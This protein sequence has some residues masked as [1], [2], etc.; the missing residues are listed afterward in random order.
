LDILFRPILNPLAVVFDPLTQ[1]ADSSDWR[2]AFVTDDL[3]KAELRRRILEPR[4]FP[5]KE[6]AVC[7]RVG[8]P[9]TQSAW[10]SILTERK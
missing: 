6:T 4:Q 9:K 7:L 2:Y 3:S 8:T 10:L 5:S 1:A